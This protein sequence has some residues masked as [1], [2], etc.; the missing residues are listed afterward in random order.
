MA[1]AGAR[2]VI[3]RDDLVEAGAG[4]DGSEERLVPSYLVLCD[5]SQGA[6]VHHAVLAAGERYG[7]E[8]EGY[9]AARGR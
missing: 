5:R 9:L 4:D 1:V 2:V 6:H 3:V 7:I 8:T